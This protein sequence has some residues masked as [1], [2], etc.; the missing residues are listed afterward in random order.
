[1]A[2]LPPQTEGVTQTSRGAIRLE[3]SP[4]NM[5]ARGSPV[6][7]SERMELGEAGPTFVPKTRICYGHSAQRFRDL[8]LCQS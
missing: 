6:K 1:M 7:V 4:P 5:V 2:T 3:C 8:T